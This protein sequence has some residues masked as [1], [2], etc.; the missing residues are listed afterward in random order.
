VELEGYEH[1]DAD[2]PESRDQQERDRVTASG[3]RRVTSDSST[4]ATASSAQTIPSAPS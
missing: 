3:R 1:D 4:A 2:D